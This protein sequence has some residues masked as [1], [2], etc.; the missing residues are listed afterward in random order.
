METLLELWRRARELR[1]ESAAF[2]AGERSLT[3][4]RAEQR[5]EA[6]ANRLRALGVGPGAKV[7]LF[8][9]GGPD[10]AVAFLA[11]LRA[12]AVACPMNPALNSRELDQLTALLEPDIALHGLQ[13]SEIVSEIARLLPTA[14]YRDGELANERVGGPD[15]RLEP[16]APGKR[17]AELDDVACILCTSGTTGLPKAGML[18]H[19]NLIS[20]VEALSLNKIWQQTEIFGNSL[21]AFH[22]YGITVLTLLPLSMAGTVVFIPRFTPEN[23]LRAIEDHGITRFGGVPSMFTLLNRYGGRDKFDFSSCRSWISGGAP[24]PRPVADE[25][26]DKFGGRIYEGYGMLETSPGI[27]WNLDDGE[28]HPGAVGRPLRGVEVRI[29]DD[30]GRAVPTG[31]IGEITVRGPG[32]MKGYYRDSEA[33][34]ETIRDGWLY[35]GD[36]GRFDEDGYLSL[37]GRTKELIIVGANNV[38]PREIEAVLLEDPEVA[39]AAVAARQD[40]VRGEQVYAFVVLEPGATLD[41]RALKLRCRESLAPY[42]VPRRVR[43][44]AEIPRNPSGKILRSQLI[45][46]LE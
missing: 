20:N 8:F 12:G 36:T 7:C 46:S 41:D 32:V 10:F 14:A 21:P 15:G 42:K 34:A 3:Y 9:A 5:I 18:T 33:T 19:A 23:C 6:L 38:Y 4:R 45:D 35:S 30:D 40:P 13:D 1:P 27:S 43:R 28:F 31:E 16:A 37:K 26:E 17:D 24:L 29:L 11:T 2:V 44:V 22:V 25:F 39:D